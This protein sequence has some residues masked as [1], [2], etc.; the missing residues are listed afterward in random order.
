M[1][2]RQMAM[3]MIRSGVTL[4]AVTPPLER[5]PAEEKVVDVSSELRQMFQKRN[6]QEVCVWNLYIFPF[7]FSG[8]PPFSL[9]FFLS[10]PLSFS[11]SFPL[12]FSPPFPLSFFHSF[13]LS[14]WLLRLK[15]TGLKQ[16]V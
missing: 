16:R 15:S 14:H 8:P 12:S 7:F 1:S 9:S 11:P 13:S 5:A 10:F 3:D 6:K 4:R 2:A